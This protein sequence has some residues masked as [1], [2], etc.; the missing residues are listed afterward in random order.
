M[1]SKSV[2]I[3][4]IIVLFILI[5]LDAYIQKGVSDKQKVLKKNIMALKTNKSNK[6]KEK[7][8]LGNTLK[9][10]LCLEDVELTSVKGL[11]DN[12]IEVELKF[13]NITNLNYKIKEIENIPG[14][15]NINSVN[16]LGSED[17][18]Y[19][20]LLHIIFIK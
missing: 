13:E 5:N 14:F 19:Y 11:D 15:K 4:L 6:V 7:Y 8:T 2:L 10:I 18:K 12:T 3:S 20:A 16:I 1:K 9:S 17:K